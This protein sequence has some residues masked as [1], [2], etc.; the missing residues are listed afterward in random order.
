[1][2]LNTEDP[3]MRICLNRLYHT[4]IIPTGC[5]DSFPKF[6]DCLFVQAVYHKRVLTHNTAQ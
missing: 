1:M 5:G 4:G 3:G 6:V 2:P